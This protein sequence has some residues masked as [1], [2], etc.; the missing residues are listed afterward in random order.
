MVRLGEPVTKL[1]GGGD[2]GAEIFDLIGWLKS[3]VLH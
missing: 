3:E 1:A 2:N